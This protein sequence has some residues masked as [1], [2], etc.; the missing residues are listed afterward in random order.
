MAIE[1]MDG[2]SPLEGLGD[3]AAKN[4]AESLYRLLD[5]LDWDHQMRLARNFY[6]K[7][8][9]IPVQP[10]PDFAERSE[11]LASLGRQQGN[12]RSM[13]RPRIAIACDLFVFGTT[14]ELKEFRQLL[15]NAEW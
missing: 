7:D 2:Q 9:F 15:G 11:I 5:G 13:L 6:E 8:Y 12:G 1:D 10:V 3:S 14:I 4:F